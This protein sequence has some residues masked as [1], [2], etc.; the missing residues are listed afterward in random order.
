VDRQDVPRL[1]GSALDRLL[2]LRREVVD[3]AGWGTPRSPGPGS[4]SVPAWRREAADQVELPGREV[5]ALSAAA[6]LTRAEI[7]CDVAG[8]AGFE[9]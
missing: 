3:R 2:Q 9:P 7:D 5:D 6:G 1:V 4:G 8:A